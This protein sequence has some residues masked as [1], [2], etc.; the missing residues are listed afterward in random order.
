[1]G[2][3]HCPLKGSHNHLIK[4]SIWPVW[5]SPQAV[6]PLLLSKNLP[7]RAQ[8]ETNMQEN[9]YFNCHEI[10]H[11]IDQMAVGKSHIV[12]RGL[13]RLKIKKHLSMCSLS[14]ESLKNRHLNT[15]MRILSQGR[16]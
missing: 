9:V 6:V 4:I 11:C 7:Q 12:V 16:H 14:R 1:M 15:N 5:T 8:I 13:I 10:Y 2:P 3:P